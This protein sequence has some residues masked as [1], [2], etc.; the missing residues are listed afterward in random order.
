MRQGE[1]LGL[2]MQDVDTKA[3]TLSVRQILNHDG[4]T[5]EAGAKSASGIRSI[6][7]DKTTA[8]ALD[9]LMHRNKEEKMANADIYER[10]N[11]L[12]CT[13]L[14]GPVS[15]R[16][17]NRSFYRLIEKADV[18]RIRFHDLRHS[19]VVMLLKMRESNKRIA[20]RMGWS[21]MKMLDRYSHITPHMQQET[22]DAFGDMFFSA[23]KGTNIAL[24]E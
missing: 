19:H 18:T 1:I 5:F 16:N 9:E 2:R 13:Q 22:A 4:K 11:L 15:P 14:G 20:E 3:R 8:G 7:I 17:I 21:S 12:I 23:P 10:H 24:V 6:G